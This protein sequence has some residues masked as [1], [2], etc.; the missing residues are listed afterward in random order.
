M[1]LLVCVATDLENVIL[2]ARLADTHEVRI[3]RMGIGPV[4][5]A[6]AVTVAIL[7]D[8][9]S[10]ILICGVG[11]AYPGS[12][13]RTGDVVS[14]DVECYGDLGAASQQGFLDMK[15]LG[16]PIVEDPQLYNDLPMQLFPTDRRVKFV[17][18]STCTGTD[19]AA[20]SI[21]TRTRGAVE[22]MEGAAVAHVAHLH[23][24]PVGE[25]RGISNIVTDRDTTK[26]R[27]LEAAQAAQ[28]AALAWIAQR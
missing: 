14:A 4:N 6:H 3:V 11:G 5:A 23:R 16:F 8:K 1:S 18:V 20:R 12:G 7:Q 2:R 21:E 19:S 28:E 26:W 22:N 13:L 10:A 15:A 17:T 24:I 9:P 27:L 25:V